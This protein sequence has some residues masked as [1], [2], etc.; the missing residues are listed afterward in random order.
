[1][2]PAIQPVD[3]EVVRG[4]NLRIRWSDG[5]LSAI[6]LT[7]L[8]KSCPCAACGTERD[9]AEQRALPIVQD[10]AAQ[11]AMVAVANAELVGR[12]ALRI[13][14]RDGHDTGIYDFALL[15]SLS[16]VQPGSLTASE[17]AK[18]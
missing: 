7:Q 10:S 8:R 11:Q 6:P 4:K 9:Q 17:A 3:I 2:D 5:G 14:W 18:G 13:T 15:R 1:M 16:P 12:Y